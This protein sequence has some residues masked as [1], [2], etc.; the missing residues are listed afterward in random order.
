M[1]VDVSDNDQWNNEPMDPELVVT[2]THESSFK[3]SVPD[4]PLERFINS[5]RTIHTSDPFQFPLTLIFHQKGEA[6]T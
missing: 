1:A 6:A 4:I 5:K 3:V 2:F